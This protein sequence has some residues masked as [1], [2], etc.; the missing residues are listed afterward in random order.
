MFGPG[1]PLTVRPDICT[2]GPL[3]LSEGQDPNVSH[4]SCVQLSDHIGMLSPIC[5]LGSMVLASSRGQRKAKSPQAHCK[6]EITIPN[7]SGSSED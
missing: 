3:A 4:I 2:G 1:L 6:L 5:L 7:W